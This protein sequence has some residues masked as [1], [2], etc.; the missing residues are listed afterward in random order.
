MSGQRHS[1]RSRDVEARTKTI[2]PGE[3]AKTTEGRAKR[4]LGLPFGLDQF[5]VNLTDLA[6]GAASALKH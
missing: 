2:Y 6:P 3:F 1:I 5:G 4:A